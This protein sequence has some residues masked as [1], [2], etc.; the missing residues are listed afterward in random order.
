ML[1]DPPQSGHAQPGAKLMQ[2]PHIRHPVLAAEAR[3]GSP[4]PL[5]RQQLD[6]QVQGMHRREQAQQMHAKELGRG[7]RVAPAA[8]AAL[9]P[10]LIDE[11]VGHQRIQ[12]FQQRHGAG[13]RQVGIHA[14]HSAAGKLP[15][16]RQCQTWQLRAHHLAG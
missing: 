2:H 9:R 16:Q 13:G 7:V 6:Q 1:V 8:G 4:S 10:G 14:R 5:L 11:I 3:E 15:R 12:A